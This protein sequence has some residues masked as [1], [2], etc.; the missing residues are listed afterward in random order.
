MTLA[1]AVS[2][3]GRKCAGSQLEIIYRSIDQL[4]LSPDN[5]RIHSN[6]QVR[7]IAR[8]IEEFGFVVPVL[9]DHQ[10]RVVAG[11]GRCQAGKLL[12]LKEVPTIALAHLT[13]AQS[14][15]FRI[16]DNRLTENAA[17]NDKLL[18]GQLKALSEADLDFSV[19][20]TGFG[21]SEIDVLIEGLAPA[22]KG[23][24]DPADALPRI[25][26][27]ARVSKPGDLWLL[28]RHR[29]YCGNSLNEV[30]FVTLMQERRAAIVIIDPPYNLAVNQLTGPGTIR[31]KNFSMAAGEITEAEFTDSLAQVCNLLAKHSIDGSIHFLFVDWRHMGEILQA[32]KQVYSELI[33]LCVWAKD[34]A[35]IGSFYRSQHKL[36][37]VFKH[38]K[39]A[40]HNNGDLV[41]LYRT[42]LWTYP[43][44]DSFSHTGEGNKPVQLV[45]DA[46]MDC[47]SRNDIVLD[48]FLGSGTTLIAAER[49]GR[50]CNGIEPDA[51]YVDIAVRRWQAF[52][53]LSATHGISGRGFNDLE[54]EAASD[55]R[56]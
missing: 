28:G 12:G 41:G 39:A 42:N 32:G 5:P 17:W 46:I 3:S 22:P 11:H 15:A 43:R 14:Q 45:A 29:L 40:H 48:C 31:H 1:G 21:V 9:V 54:Q 37:F 18:A 16:A 26:T 30:N 13:E 52:T 36:V 20:V 49:T 53:G 55:R 4:R 56:Q 19:D 25:V 50:I 34:K 51:D 8:S 10:L 44:V 6:K 33:N 24:V 35:G 7:Q 38:G 27:S 23:K 2:K 47:S